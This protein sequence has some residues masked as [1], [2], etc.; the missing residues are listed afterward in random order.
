MKD[1]KVI[2]FSSNQES[3]GAIT[4]EFEM[5]RTDDD[6]F[7]LTEKLIRLHGGITLSISAA[8]TISNL[9]YSIGL[10]SEGVHVFSSYGFKQRMEAGDPTF[11]Y[12]AINGHV[13][14][15]TL[16]T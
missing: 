9:S 14:Q 6:R 3:E 13:L 10:L 4:L 12:T 16:G 15:I 11:M 8:I 1:P 5:S 2:V 7:D